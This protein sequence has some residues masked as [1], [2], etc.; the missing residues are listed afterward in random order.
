MNT[1]HIISFYYYIYI[2]HSERNMRLASFV[3]VLF[4][5]VTS[6]FAA[7]GSSGGI[8]GRVIELKTKQPL[9]G[10]NVVLL[11]T[12]LGA[13]TDASGEYKIDNLPESV[14]KINVSF[15]GFLTHTETDI[16]VVRNKTTRVTDIQLAENYFKTDSIV[17]SSNAFSNDEISLVSG[18]TYQREEIRR[19]PGASGDIFRAI[20]TLPGVSSS[21]GEFSAFSVRGGSPRDNLILID[22]IP[23][24]KVAHFDGGTEDQEAQGG[25]FSIFAPGLINEAKFQAGGFSAKNSGKNASIIELALKEGN[26]KTAKMDA[27]YDPIGWEVNYDGPI[28]LAA[29]TG[30]LFSARHQDFTNILKWTGQKDLGYPSYSDYIMKLTT[31]PDNQNKLSFIAI[32]APEWMDR[33]IDNVYNTSETYDTQIYN[34]KDTKQLYGINWQ[35][36]LSSSSYLQ[37][38]AYFKTD[39]LNY[40]S[41][42]VYAYT[43]DEQKVPQADALVKKNLLTS[44]DWEKQFGGRLQYTKSFENSLTLQLGFDAFRGVYQVTNNLTQPDTSFVFDENDYRPDPTKYYIISLPQNVDN[45]LK[46]GYNEFSWYADLS[47]HPIANLQLNPSIRYD[48]NSLNR[49]EYV[50]PRLSLRYWL[51]ENITLNAAAGVYY[52]DPD[53]RIIS[54]DNENQSL[55]SEKALHYILGTSMYLTKSLKATAESYYKDYSGLI[56]RP[57][58]TSYRFINEGKA[59]AYGLDLGLVKRFDDN[60][61]GQLNY[62]YA[63]SKRNDNDRFGWYT[64]PFNQPHV[65]NILVGFEVNSNL[66]VSM[67]WKYGTGRPK[68]A[69]IVHADVL[70]DPQNI[71]YS[72]EI[73]SKNS[74]R[75]EDFHTFNVRVDYR[76]QYEPCAIVAYLDILN[77]YSHLNVNEERFLDYSGTVS[78]KGFG[79][80]PTMGVKLEF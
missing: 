62:S 75:L 13:V 15:V 1:V 4:T 70:N 17:V 55:Q 23:F 73:T 72:K 9:P 34:E 16:R 57:D 32:Y 52:Q 21:G 42:K 37:A 71:R 74:E 45:N 40:A 60:W 77:L 63:E 78:K 44:H 5:M 29:N 49:K 80:M 8:S 66:T 20:E 51:T 67:K 25:R 18:Y 50:S 30:L 39:I 2:N 54:L 48:V 59:W 26:T 68:S 58:R 24:D 46:S 43:G 27:T 11:G 35:N 10:V 69:Y 64:S 36:F 7:E 14:Y 3:L 12:K 22:N 31:M 47:L 19:S 33:N 65:F 6:L 56:Y 79:I 41:G 53:L 28:S 76:K 38:T 61:Y